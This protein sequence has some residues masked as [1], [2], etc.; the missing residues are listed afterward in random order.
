MRRWATLL[1]VAALLL[2]GLTA[3]SADDPAQ[4]GPP[5]PQD[6]EKG[7]K[8]DVEAFLDELEGS[9]DDGATAHVTFAVSG[10]V[11]LHGR[12]SVEYGDDGM[13][14]DLRL[15]DWQP[16]GG[17]VDLRTVGDATYMRVPES[18]GLWVAIGADDLG[19]TDSVLQDADPRAQLDGARDEIT[20]VRYSGED[21][22]AGATV[23]RYQV[24]AK[25]AASAAPGASGPA[26]TDYWFDTDGRVV[27]RSVDLGASGSASFTWADWDT[28]VDIVAP[29]ET[30]T[31]TVRE[32]EKLRRRQSAG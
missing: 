7:E 6:A 25:V 30:R 16:G 28:P 4:A 29:P 31:I 18:R 24:V 5:R 19:L 21:T 27:R 12:G 17:T 32:L 9:F 3:C 15:A 23:R 22:L 11:K 1:P 14:V 20:E 10:Q 26:V 8:V 13:D 2:P